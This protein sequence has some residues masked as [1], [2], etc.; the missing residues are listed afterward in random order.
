MISFFIWGFHNIKASSRYTVY[1]RPSRTIKHLLLY[2]FHRV[3]SFLRSLNHWGEKS[4]LF[5]TKRLPQIGISD[6]V[7]SR[8]ILPTTRVVWGAAQ[9]FEIRCSYTIVVIIHSHHRY[10]SPSMVFK[11]I[12]I[13]F[14]FKVFVRLCVRKGGN[15]TYRS[16]HKDSPSP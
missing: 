16:A 4:L 10:Q 6:G 5:N 13:V 15:Y 2:C 12:L 11:C 8:V 7:L 14:S 9:V 1:S 3:F